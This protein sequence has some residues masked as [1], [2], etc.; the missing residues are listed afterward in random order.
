[1]NRPIASDPKPFAIRGGSKKTGNVTNQSYDEDNDMIS[2]Q[3]LAWCMILV[4]V[5]AS[6]T[7]FGQNMGMDEN[8][9]AETER[10]LIGILN[11]TAPPQDKAIPCKQLAIYG[12]KN[13]VPALAALLPD[14]NLSSWARIALEVIPD[15][16]A[17]EALRNALGKLNGRLL[18]GV[19][20]SIAFR[21]D[22]QAVGG[23]IQKLKDNDTEVSCAA[24]VALGKIG[25]DQAA[26]ALVPLLMSAPD[27][28]RTAVAEGCILCAERFVADQ[29]ADSA[30]TL[31]EAV[32]KAG[33]P[34]QRILEATRGAILARGPSGIGL[35]IEQ[36]K[37]ADQA[38]FGIG[39]RTARELPGIEV[40][41]S[42]AAELN[43]LDSDRQSL[44]LMAVADRTDAA[45]LPVVLAAAAPNSPKSTRTTAIKLLERIGNVTCVPALID[46]AAAEDSV[47]AQAARV[48]F[49]R[50]QGKDVDADLLMRLPQSTG[51]RR[52]AILELVGLRQI[53][54]AAGSIEPAIADSDAGIRAAAVA[55]LGIIG[56]DQ[57]APALVK[58]L[59]KNPAERALIEKALLAICGRGKAGCLPYVMPLAQNANADLRIVAIHAMAVIGGSDAMRAINSAVSDK[60]QAVQ[61]EAV[62]TLSTWPNNWPEDASI[63]QPLLSLAQSGTSMSHQVLALRGYLQYLQVDKKLD[64][65]AKT[66][67]VNEILPLIKRPE[68]KRLAIGVLGTTPSTEAM[69]LLR[70]MAEDPA[71]TEDADSAIVNLAGKSQALPKELRQK[72]LQTVIDTSKNANMKKKAQE[73]LRSIQ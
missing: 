39:L 7:S 23:L 59:E 42:L 60:E 25:G 24:A 3:R 10:K 37:S 44:L 21:R 16:A 71:V 33:V 69:D 5:L 18:V 8:T 50:L 27:A 64:G 56:N 48:S 41:Q 55:T 6:A 15:P 29:K 49:S 28:I 61:D 58:L 45:V 52:Q 73:I 12:S 13:A 57:Q 4:S 30:I 62:R 31:Y 19:I 67:K 1:M 9:R 35:L 36:L 34:K 68:E 32:R 40:T 53:A 20:H 11:S 17:D 14:A 2:I 51:R 66:A 26:G 38:Q 22:A 47:L 46:A 63:A 43:H 54:G 70:I 65:K 72:A